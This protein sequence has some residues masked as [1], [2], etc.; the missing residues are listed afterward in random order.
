MGILMVCF[1]DTESEKDVLA[2][3]AFTV[4]LQVPGVIE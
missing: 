4:S 1:Q 2:V 3:P